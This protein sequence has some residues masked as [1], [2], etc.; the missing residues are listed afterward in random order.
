VG[1]QAEDHLL[2]QVGR[3]GLQL[4]EIPILR[5]LL[6]RMA[7]QVTLMAV[8]QVVLQVALAEALIPLALRPEAVVEVPLQELLAA[9]RQAELSLHIHKDSLWLLQLLSTS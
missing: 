9:V 5:V 8:R 4:V 2:M 1:V 3:Q 7:L 6:G